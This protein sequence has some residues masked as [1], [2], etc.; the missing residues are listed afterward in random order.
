MELPPLMEVLTY[1]EASVRCWGA[2]GPRSALYRVG[3]PQYDE[4]KQNQ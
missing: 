2:K 3:L 1:V 4:E